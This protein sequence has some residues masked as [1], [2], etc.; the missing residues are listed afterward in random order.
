[1]PADIVLSA[2]PQASGPDADGRI[3]L[4]QDNTVIRISDAEFGEPFAVTCKVWP[5]NQN[6]LLAAVPLMRDAPDDEN[7]HDGD[8]L[9][10]VLERG[11]L[12]VRQQRRLQGLMSDDAVRIAGLSFD[13]ARYDVTADRRAFGLRISREG[14]S[15]ANPFSETSLRLFDIGD[16]GLDLVLDGLIVDRSNGEWDT[17]CAG[18]FTEHAVSLA[19]SGTLTRGYRD[20]VATDAY[21]SSRAAVQ[22][23]ECEEKTLSKG[24]TPRTLKFDG[25]RY[26]IPEP[27]RS[28]DRETAG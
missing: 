22:H 25:Q 5:A 23:G 4:G 20:I 12:K 13:T 16:L 14:S 27:L 3:H 8:L 26:L 15:R 18:E 2:S 6:L 11:T 9:V 28:L 21:E 19:M 7:G 1:M 10:L 24:K 17:N